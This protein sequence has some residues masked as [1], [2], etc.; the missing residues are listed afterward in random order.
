MANDAY[1]PTNYIWEAANVYDMDV[2]SDE[3]KELVVRLYQNLNAVQ[4]GVNARDV[5][6]YDT[7]EFVC[8]QLFFPNPTRNANTSHP[9]RR[10]VYRLVVD[11]G[12]LPN[13]TTK[14]VAHNL[15][16]TGGYSFTRLYG[17]SS[18][19]SNKRY[20]PIPN[21]NTDINLEVDATNVKIKTSGTFSSFTTTYVILEYIKQ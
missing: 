9:D 4:F 21:A 12:A 10:Q 8:G 13:S 17:A 7:N 19:P 5:G 15:T 16:I 20:I 1:I 14:S 11:F 6:T 2:T 3:F 18:D